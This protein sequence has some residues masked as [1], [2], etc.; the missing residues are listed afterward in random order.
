MKRRRRRKGVA[1]KRYQ[2][3]RMESR[4]GKW[5]KD[6]WGKKGVGSGVRSLVG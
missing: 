5:K 6:N 1:E 2:T 3:G 4:W